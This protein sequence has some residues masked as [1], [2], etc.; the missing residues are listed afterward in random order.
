MASPLTPTTISSNR[1]SV[2]HN[3]SIKEMDNFYAKQRRASNESI[4]IDG[5]NNNNKNPSYQS[6]ETQNSYNRSH[7]LT[8]EKSKQSS[9]RRFDSADEADE[10]VRKIHQQGKFN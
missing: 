8:S 9:F 10:E 1:T 4:S 6:I 3:S 2:T 7:S 5:V